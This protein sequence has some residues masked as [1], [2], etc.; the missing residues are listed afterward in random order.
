MIDTSYQYSD[1]MDLSHGY[2][3]KRDQLL[4]NKHTISEF[5]R[6]RFVYRNNR[7]SD[8]YRHYVSVYILLLFDFFPFLFLL[9]L[10]NF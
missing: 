3:F 8:Q 9:A 5:I 10:C 1:Q 6:E 4:E 7:K 2:L